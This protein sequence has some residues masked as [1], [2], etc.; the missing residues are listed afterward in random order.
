M[1][2]QHKS[3]SAGLSN[4][5]YVADTIE[6]H[7]E[8]HGRAYDAVVVSEV[9]EHV[10]EKEH[11]LRACSACLKPG[12]SMFVTTMNH[13]L[14]A[15]LFGIVAAEN[16]FAVAPKGIHEWDK[17]ISPEDLAAILE[18]CGCQSKMLHGFWYN[19]FTNTWKIS[20]DVSINYGIHAI[21]D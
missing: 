12:G 8:T 4:L 6:A 16:V 1:A 14:T 21:K 3:L 17:F 11:F 7:S 13:T 5:T 15:W 9:V 19:A 2:K 20:K 10:T 18:R